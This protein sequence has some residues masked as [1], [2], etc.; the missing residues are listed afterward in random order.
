MNYT[1]NLS[2]SIQVIR[3]LF[4]SLWWQ[5]ID[6]HASGISW[7]W[8]AKLFDSLWW[9]EIDV[10]ASEMSW[11]WGA[12]IFVYAHMLRCDWCKTWVCSSHN[13]C[14]PQPYHSFP[15]PSNTTLVLS[16]HSQ[17]AWARQ[18]VNP[19]IT[20]MRNVTEGMTEGIIF[21]F[22]MLSPCGWYWLRVIITQ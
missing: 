1:V 21:V 8:G 5:E 13:R 11:P 6:I 18:N 22:K 16:N 4:D 2:P 3:K 14:P 20:Y 12:T 7:P 9:Q 19:Q 15:S 10:H 17:P